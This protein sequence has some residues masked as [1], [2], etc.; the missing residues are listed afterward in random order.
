MSGEVWIGIGLTVVGAGLPATVALM[1][2]LPQ[3]NG[4]SQACP[5][6]E[7]EARMGSIEKSVAV[8]QESSSHIKASLL[9][10]EQ[11]LEHIGS[12]GDA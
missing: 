4:R 11:R 9:R 10:I 3:K 1:R 2:L 7:H 8:L 12:S 6:R 5:I